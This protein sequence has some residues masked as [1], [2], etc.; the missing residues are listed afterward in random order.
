M[1]GTSLA[2][3]SPLFLEL[4]DVGK[5]RSSNSAGISLDQLIALNDEIAALVRAG[6]PLELGLKHIG[7]DMPGRPGTLAATLSAEME[8]GQTLAEVVNHHSESFPPIYR[9]IV[10]AGVRAGNL[11]AALESVA[12]CARR[13][14]EIRRLVLASSIY[15]LLVF[16]LAWGLFLFFLKKI[17]PVFFSVFQ[18]FGTPG[19]S[20]LEQFVRLGDSMHYWGPAVPAIVI[21]VAAV[22]LRG[23]SRANLIGSQPMDWLLALVPFLGSMRRS[24]RVA[25]F[26][27]ILTLLASND[28]P[29][30]EAVV[31]AAESVGDQRMIDTSR[32]IAE[33]I[34][35]GEQFSLRSTGESPFPPFLDWMIQS[36]QQRGALL[37]ALRHASDSYYRRAFRQASATRILL[38]TAMVVTIGGGVT[39]VYALMLFGP[40]VSLLHCLEK[41]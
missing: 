21:L 10:T 13:L 39:L 3:S 31:L 1:F 25:A 23:T 34:G 29:L 16:L 19:T 18:D 5:E 38:P 20:L 41:P 36:G 40:W 12:G 2:A 15:P 37:P 30:D 11:S 6:I 17:V 4:L 14:A 24:F 9:A 27:D 33:S 22:W 8:R 28:V 7:G 35:R 32:D 26:A